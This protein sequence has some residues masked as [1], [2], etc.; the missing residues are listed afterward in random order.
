MIVG[1]KATAALVVPLLRSTTLRVIS[2]WPEK[3][4]PAVREGSVLGAGGKMSAWKESALRGTTKATGSTQEYEADEITLYARAISHSATLRAR[5]GR[6][7]IP[8]CGSMDLYSLRRWRV[9]DSY[10]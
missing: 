7:H 1:G 10:S 8:R 4:S 6:K 2:S 9:S 5:R 3:N